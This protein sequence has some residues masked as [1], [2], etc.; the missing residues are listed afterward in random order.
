MGIH[1]FYAA[2]WIS[3]INPSHRIISPGC[4]RPNCC[5]SQLVAWVGRR[6]QDCRAATR[7]RAP[8]PIGRLNDRPI[9][10]EIPLPV[11]RPNGRFADAGR[12]TVLIMFRISI[13]A[14]WYFSAYTSWFSAGGNEYSTGIRIAVVAVT[15]IC[16]KSHLLSSSSVWALRLY[17]PTF[18]CSGNGRVSPASLFNSPSVGST[19]P[20]LC[21]NH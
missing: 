14:N 5:P 8:A 16:W 11:Q 4:R 21:E 15:P 7:S 20:I 17:R 13:A 3:S 12:Q 6:A 9:G 19:R 10:N 18:A 2:P 1:P